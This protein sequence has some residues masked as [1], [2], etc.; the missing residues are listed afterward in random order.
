MKHMS[1]RWRYL[2]VV[3]VVIGGL[4]FP[5]AQRAVLLDRSEIEI[6]NGPVNHRR[7]DRKLAQGIW[8][9]EHI[10]LEV[11]EHGATLEYDC[12]QGTISR[13]ILLD[14]RGRFDVVGQHVPEH[15]GPVRQNEQPTGYPVRFTGR[16][17]GKLM[18]LTLRDSVTNKVIGNFILSYGREPRLIKCR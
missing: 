7:A 4:A 18:T 10:S 14:R 8:G 13:R 16:V 3:F 2:I 1:G 17:N 12:A 9:G 15:G 11:T 5:P 6:Y